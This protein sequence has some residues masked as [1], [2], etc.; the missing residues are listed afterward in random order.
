MYKRISILVVVI[1]G[2]LLLCQSDTQRTT[3]VTK[4]GYIWWEFSSYNV[5][6]QTDS[7]FCQVRTC[8][9]TVMG[10]TIDQNCLYKSSKIKIN[11]HAI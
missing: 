1:I 3:I 11:S 2:I 5:C 10:S 9:T 4:K 6:Q 8:K 7:Q